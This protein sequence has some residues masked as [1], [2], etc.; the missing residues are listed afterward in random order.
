MDIK[1]QIETLG[2]AKEKICYQEPM[3]KHTT[4]KIGGPAECLIKVEKQEELKEILAIAN[5]NKIPITVIGN[6]SNLLV[7]DKGI[8]G[9]TLMIKIEKMEKQEKGEKIQITVGAGEKIGKLARNMLKRRNNRNGRTIWHTRYNWWS[10]SNECRSSWKR[11]ERHRE[12]R[13]MH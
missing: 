11:N 1:K 2:I 8:K 4:F 5:Q 12:K 7:L 3:K 9:I 6:G 10:C 13:K